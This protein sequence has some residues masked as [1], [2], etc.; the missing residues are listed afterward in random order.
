[1]GDIMSFFTP[2]L[3]LGCAVLAIAGLDLSLRAQN[4][5]TV[6]LPAPSGQ[7]PVG[8]ASFDWTDVTRFDPLAPDKRKRELTVWIWYPASL[9]KSPPS[10]V[11]LPPKWRDA[12]MGH[13]PPG[14][15][16]MYRNLPHV[17]CHSFDQAD[18]V[19]GG[20]SYP[21][22]LLKPG[23][24]MLAL[25]YSALCEDLASHGY[26]VVASDSPF[27]TT[28]VVYSDGRVVA[29]GQKG[30]VTPSEATSL[31]HV[32]ADD[33]RF[34]ANRLAALN[35]DGKFRGRLD[36]NRIGVFGHSFGGATAV[37][38]CRIDK[39][40]RA[41]IEVD[42][43]PFGDAIKT[44]LRRPFMFLMSDQKDVSG[45]EGQQVFTDINNIFKRS[46]TGRRYVI[47]RGSAHFSF[48]DLSVF[49]NLPPSQRSGPF[50]SIDGRRG[51]M[52]GSACICAFFDLNLKGVSASR[53]GRLPL[54]YPEL[55]VKN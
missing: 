31:L 42:G 52:A 4:K 18:F 32:W 12:L 55:L 49:M 13:L 45:A 17:Q 41:G 21:V 26:V 1:M 28:V 44:G 39:R 2:L 48:S 8:R 14:I 23:I 40:C 9:A 19:R 51:L 53:F 11:Y 36:M 35:R 30:E 7:F 46:S 24:G 3:R 50:G 34:L 22:I 16:P 5:T 33:E 20:R 10:S 37:E 27:N 25:E 54:Q 6:E 15:R 29:S 38:F 47:L 43:R